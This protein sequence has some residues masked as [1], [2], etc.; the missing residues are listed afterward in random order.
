VTMLVKTV[1]LEVGDDHARD[2]AR[3]FLC[4]PFLL[5]CEESAPHTLFGHGMK[6]DEFLNK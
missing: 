5:T 1:K 3:A 6:I 2:E 4:K